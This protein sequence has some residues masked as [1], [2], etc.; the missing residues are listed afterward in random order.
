MKPSD[1]VRKGFRISQQ[2]TRTRP[3]NHAYS[4]GAG[5]FSGASHAWTPRVLSRRL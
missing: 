1:E 5:G 4:F 3:F 2:S